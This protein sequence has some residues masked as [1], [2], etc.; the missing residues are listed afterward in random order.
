MCLRAHEYRIFL[1]CADASLGMT[2]CVTLKVSLTEG[3][4]RPCPN[5]YVKSHLPPNWQTKT[6]K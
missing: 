4:E 5:I 6:G 1:G 3:E 2:W